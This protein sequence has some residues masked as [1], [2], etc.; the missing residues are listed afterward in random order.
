VAAAGV[1]EGLKE[2]LIE[3]VAHP[4]RRCRDAPGAELSRVAR[5]LIR[6]GH[7][8][9]GQAVRQQQA[10]IDATLDEVAGDLFTAAEPALPEVGAAAGIHRP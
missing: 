10:A 1:G 4:E 6:I 7:P 8:D 5:E 2:P 9:V 3:V